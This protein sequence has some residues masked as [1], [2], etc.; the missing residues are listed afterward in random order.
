M[1]IARLRA[2][3]SVGADARVLSSA[4]PDVVEARRRETRLQA[5]QVAEALAWRASFILPTITEMHSNTIDW[6]AVTAIATAVTALA[7]P[8][9]ALFIILQ[10][11][12]GRELSQFQVYQNL[13]DRAERVHLNDALA[14]VRSL[15]CCTYQE[16]QALSPATQNHVKRVVEFFNEIQHLI[17]PD[18]KMLKLQYVERLWGQSI[19]TCTNQLWKAGQDA[20]DPWDSDCPPSW[21]L[22]GFRRENGSNYFYRGFERLC[23]KIRYRDLPL[24]FK[25]FRPRRDRAWKKRRHPRYW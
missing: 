24:R 12:Q 4:I 22:T 5:G 10:L 3:Y 13:L 1:Q 2:G 7:V 16:Y 6:A 14:A 19:L 25:Y 18:A 17:P 9:S 11:R 20:R 8:A 15:T 21:W 23:W